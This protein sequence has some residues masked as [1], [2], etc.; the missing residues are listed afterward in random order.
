MEQHMSLVL[1]QSVIGALHLGPLGGFNGFP[2]VDRLIEIAVADLKALQYGGVDGVLFQN[3]YDLPHVENMTAK[4]Y[5][6]LRT[7]GQ[8]LKNNAI[9]PLGVNVVWND[10]RS[11]LKL[12]KELDLAFIRVPVYVDNVTTKYG[13][14]SPVSKGLRNFRNA[15]GAT[16]V[17]V[18]ADIRTN[19]GTTTSSSTRLESARLA[20][21]A[22]ADAIIVTGE[23]PGIAPHVDD[24]RALRDELDNFPILAGN[25]VTTANIGQLLAASSGV[26]VGASLKYEP[27]DRPESYITDW[28]QRVEL[29]RVEA[30][31]LASK[32]RQPGMSHFN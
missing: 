23:E 18:Y 4:N 7:I 11:A 17:A 32:G 25:G 24:L 27:A 28:H 29:E 13:S 16:S 12:A 8:E 30:L 14:Y 26:I 2:G 21:K 20:A 9:V 6:L 1:N 22:G 3:N 15:L 31:V 19:L 10:Y 5:E